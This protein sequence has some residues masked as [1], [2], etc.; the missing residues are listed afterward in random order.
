MC[1]ANLRFISIKLLLL[2]GLIWGLLGITGY[3]VLSRLLRIIGIPQLSRVIYIMIGIATMIII[4]T[5]KPTTIFPTKLLTYSYPL[6][7]TIEKSMTAPTGANFIVYWDSLDNA[8]NSGIV[9]VIDGSA[10]IRYKATEA[11]IYYR[12]GTDNG[13][14]TQINKID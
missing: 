3:N 11:P 5:D 1:T 6:D 12:W 10:K 14:L 2:G 13:H 7:Y 9:K 4:L 8:G